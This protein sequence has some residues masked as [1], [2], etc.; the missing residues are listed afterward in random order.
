[1]SSLETHHGLD[2]RP[3][4]ENTTVVVLSEM[5][6]TPKLNST[7]GKDHWTFTSAMLIGSG[8]R[9]G[10]AVGGYDDTL[11]G[12]PTDLGSGETTE[13]GTPLTAAHLGATLM[14]LADI[15]PAE[16]T[17]ATPVTALLSG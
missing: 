10:Q 2:G 14:A 13:S 16:F 9:G 3:L 4:S 5:G 12:L 11:M 1:M 17:D 7:G 8:I 6:R 15:D